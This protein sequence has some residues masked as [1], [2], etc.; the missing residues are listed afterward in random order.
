MYLVCPKPRPLLNH[1]LFLF[2]PRGDAVPINKHS[3]ESVYRTG[4]VFYTSKDSESLQFVCV[5]EF[6]SHM[7]PSG[8]SPSLLVQVS[9]IA[10][11]H[12]GWGI[13]TGTFD[14]G[15]GSSACCSVY[16]GPLWPAGWK[17]QSINALVSVWEQLHSVQSC[18]KKN[19]A[20]FAATCQS[21]A[22]LILFYISTAWKD[23]NLG[24]KR[25]INTTSKSFHQQ[26]FPRGKHFKYDYV[27]YPH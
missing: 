12:P 4:F 1:A 22:D 17:N 18:N 13:A 15:V 27:T 9:S 19:I 7:C 5:G 26:V 10:A 6:D 20:R 14:F 11:F 3:Y 25:H 2:G 24:V 21:V 16:V 23:F 8:L